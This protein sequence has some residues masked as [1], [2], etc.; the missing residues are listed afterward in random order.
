MKSIFKRFLCLVAVAASFVV[1]G[2][3]A[4]AQRCTRRIKVYNNPEVLS[5]SI[6]L[7]PGKHVYLSD[8]KNPM[9]K[10]EV[11]I[12]ST[13][14]IKDKKTGIEVGMALYVDYDDKTL[15]CPYFLMNTYEGR[16]DVTVTGKVLPPLV[17]SWNGHF[18]HGKLT[19]DELQEVLDESMDLDEAGFENLE[20]SLTHED[21]MKFQIEREKV[22]K[23][24]CANI[25]ILLKAVR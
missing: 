7:A 14:A 25:G 24:Y 15:G 21:L 22:K 17:V 11:H 12:L 3:V 20:A 2:T 23:G 16:V 18:A 4:N 10:F 5:P 1:V 13:N 6:N 9:K 8:N 19:G